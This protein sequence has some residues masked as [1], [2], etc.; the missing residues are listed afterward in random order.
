MLFQG[1]W[2]A[3]L[4]AT[5]DLGKATS[6]LRLELLNT[7]SCFFALLVSHKDFLYCAFISDSV[8]V[9]DALVALR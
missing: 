7:F 3:S 6:E 8:N 4:D 2:D 1:D 5:D 9:K